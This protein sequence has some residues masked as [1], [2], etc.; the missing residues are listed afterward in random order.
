[1]ATPFGVVCGGAG[2]G[3]EVQRLSKPR[4]TLLAFDAGELGELADLEGSPFAGLFRASHA[5][6]CCSAVLREDFPVP[7]DNGE[8]GAGK[9]FP[10]G[11]DTDRSPKLLD[12]DISASTNGAREN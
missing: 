10:P 5:T 6:I 3:G 9:P 4:E 11:D 12:C 1:M 2:W 8:L 7:T